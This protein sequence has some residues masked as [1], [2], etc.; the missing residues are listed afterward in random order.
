[1]AHTLAIFCRCFGSCVNTLPASCFICIY[2][3][4]RTLYTRWKL[5]ANICLQCYKLPFLP[6][7]QGLKLTCW[8]GPASAPLIMAEYGL[9]R[10]MS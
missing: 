9:L 10:N 5:Q 3:I 4:N 7:F 8:L 6:E 1:L 2:S